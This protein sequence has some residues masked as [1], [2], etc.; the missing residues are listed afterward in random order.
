[1]RRG[2]AF[3]GGV[4]RRELDGTLR[5]PV[6]GPG[7]EH[8]AS[9]RPAV[10]GVRLQRLLAD[11]GVGARRACER[12]IE[13]GRVAVNGRIVTRLPVF[14]DPRADRITVNGRPV[15]RPARPV[16]VLL[17]K[18]ARVLAASADQPG[19]DRRTIADFVRHPSGAR[20]FPVGRLEYDATGLVLLTNDGDL[21]ARLTHPRFEVP[22]VYRAVV[23]GAV[24]EATLPR[25]EREILKSQRRAS[26][27]AGRLHASRASFAIVD[28][29]PER[30]LL[31]VTLRQGRVPALAPLLAAAGHPLRKLEQVT[32]GPLRL[33]G[34]AK[35]RWRDL[36]RSE[37]QSLRRLVRS[38]GAA[39]RGQASGKEDGR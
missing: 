31:E 20:L 19:A 9:A 5:L 22:K 1:M 4:H 36:D 24:A 30:T 7:R 13:E 12:L 14:V 15:A 18:P 32:L 39:A 6:S 11:A 27:Q 16:Y 23:R 28:R 17:H 37:V 25:L 10:R 33:T 3:P 38:N 21:A 35:G 29:T 2:T 34:V 8:G 26:R